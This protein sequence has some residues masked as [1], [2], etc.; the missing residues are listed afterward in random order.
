M[1]KKG[2]F[3]I[4]VKFNGE[5]IVDQDVNTIKEVGN[6]FEDVKRKFK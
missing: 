3:D 1:S 6:I 4:K 2:I 5:R